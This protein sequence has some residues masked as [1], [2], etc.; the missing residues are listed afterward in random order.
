MKSSG[1]K[2]AYLIFSIINRTDDGQYTCRAN[3]SAGNDQNQVTLVLHCKLNFVFMFLYIS[4]QMTT[5]ELRLY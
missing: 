1:Y 5:E 3:N 4:P 2:T